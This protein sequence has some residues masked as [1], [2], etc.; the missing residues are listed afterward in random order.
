MLISPD[1]S[2]VV[3]PVDKVTSPDV[4]ASADTSINDPEDIPGP[5]VIDTSPP[6]RSIDLP[7]ENKI[8]P[9]SCVLLAPA[10]AS[11]SPD[12]CAAFPDENEI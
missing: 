10:L 1:F 12:F 3:K 6:F 8:L 4:S 11:M 9:P 7:A 5:L 2:S